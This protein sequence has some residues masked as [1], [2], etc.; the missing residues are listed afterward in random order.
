[1]SDESK[2]S[3]GTETATPLSDV[4]RAATQV[5]FDRVPSEPSFETL[6]SRR[7]R[8]LSYRRMVRQR[9]FAMMG[10]GLPKSWELIP[11]EARERAFEAW[12]A[13]APPRT[14]FIREVVPVFV[15]FA[16]PRWCAESSVS[17]ALRDLIR[18]EMCKWELSYRPVT[19][20]PGPCEFAFELVP[21]M[22][23]ALELLELEYPV[24]EKH[25]E[26]ETLEPRAT[27][28]CVYRD[29][30]DHLI[31]TLT[32]NAVTLDI[33]R[34]WMRGEKTVADAVKGVAAARNTPIDQKFIAGLTTVLEDFIQRGVVLGSKE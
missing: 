27:R 18:Y 15:E 8:W 31:Y 11:R 29:G 20:E 30:T 14:R 32:L 19:I 33:V 7:D 1:M 10:Q 5:C 4:L 34:E 21:A 3:G 17:G 25:D 26:L 13:E 23:P 6:M 24:N 9:L 12:L 22:N 16:L 2:L 28:L